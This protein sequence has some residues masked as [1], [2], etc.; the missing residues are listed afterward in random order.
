MLIISFFVVFII[1]IMLSVLIYNYFEKC[2]ILRNKLIK[3]GISSS[4]FSH[5]V[6]AYHLAYLKDLVYEKETEATEKNFVATYQE[7]K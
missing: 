4:K 7:L 3:L 1:I 5:S 6:K 2:R